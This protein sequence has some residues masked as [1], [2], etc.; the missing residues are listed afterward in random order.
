MNVQLKR[1]HCLFIR[2]TLNMALTELQVLID[3]LLVL[4]CWWE[5]RDTCTIFPLFIILKKIKIVDS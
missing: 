2:R 5:V 4:Q 1:K 3:L